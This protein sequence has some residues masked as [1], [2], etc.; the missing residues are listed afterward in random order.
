MRMPVK[1]VYKAESL[2][3]SYWL[4][5]DIGLQCQVSA[6]ILCCP[7]PR[8]S[9]ELEL[10][11]AV[12]IRSPIAADCSDRISNSIN[13]LIQLSSWYS[14]SWFFSEDKYWKLS[15]T[16]YASWCTRSRIGLVTERKVAGSPV[17]TPPQATL[18]KLLT[19]CGLRSK[20]IV[21]IGDGVSAGCTVSA[22][23]AHANR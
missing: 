18:N 1:F 13:V 17:T 7:T 11:A 5:S 2:N 14:S 6:L 8:G 16:P 4:H 19:C 12:L 9:K 20:G 15:S 21:V 22:A 3:I 10:T 23:M